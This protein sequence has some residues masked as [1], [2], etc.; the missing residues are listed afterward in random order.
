MEVVSEPETTLS[1]L[2]TAPEAESVLSFG[3]ELLTVVSRFEL[4]ADE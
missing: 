3:R 2:S 4:N 1:L